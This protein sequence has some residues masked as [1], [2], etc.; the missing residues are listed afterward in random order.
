MPPI[1][2]L[3]GAPTVGSFLP[4]AGVINVACAPAFA[5]I[6]TV[7]SIDAGPGVLQS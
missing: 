7:V 3:A 2:A 1:Y 4:V 5:G 6:S